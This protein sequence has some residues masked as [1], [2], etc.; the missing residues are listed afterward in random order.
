METVKNVM[1][2]VNEAVMGKPEPV[3]LEGAPA[4]V[5]IKTFMPN[6]GQELALED[7]LH[8][9]FRTL[10]EAGLTAKPEPFFLRSRAGRV[11][12]IFEWRD[13]EALDEAHNNPATKASWDALMGLST[14]VPLASL[15]ESSEDYAHFQV[16]N[17]KS[18]QNLPTV[19][20][21]VAQKPYQG[22]EE[23]V[24]RLLK[25]HD[26]TLRKMG[27]TTDRPVLWLRGEKEGHVIEVAEWRSEQ[28]LEEGQ[29][30]EDVQGLWR[31]F[32]NL[33]ENT[34]LSDLGDA[35]ERYTLLPAVSGQ[36]A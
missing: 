33:S 10:K 8:E 31:Q 20:K 24:I 11:I 34:R 23:E 9:H 19:A 16:I 4:M 3:S 27:F 14:L 2:S 17:P 12:E 35:K 22:K 1:E 5:C 26:V 7:A 15:G 6:P 36:I 30:H 28:K 29:Q 13:S 25:Q 18:H 32:D 21:I